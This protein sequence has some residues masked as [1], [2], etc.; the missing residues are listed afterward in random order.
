MSFLIVNT[1]RAASR[2]FYL[3]LRAQPGLLT[4]S[5][6]QF[7]NM[8]TRYICLNFKGN[9][10][11]LA[12][13]VQ[14]ARRITESPLPH[15]IVFHGAR[16]RLAYPFNSRRNKALLTAVRNE[17]GIDSVF[18]VIRDSEKCFL[19]ELNRRLAKPLGDWKFPE[20]QLG[21]KKT[22][23]VEDLAD[24]KSRRIPHRDPCLKDQLKPN[25]DI[26][27]LARKSSVRT[28]KLFAMY[29]LFHS[30]FPEVY[31][32]R[33]ERFL[34][35]PR[36]IFDQIAS[37]IGF[38]FSDYSLAEI[39][40]NS[41]SNRLLIYNP[42]TLSL[43]GTDTRWGGNWHTSFSRFALRQGRQV[44]LR[45]EIQ[46][47]IQLCDDWGVYQPLGPDCSKA[48][49]HVANDLGGRIGIGVHVDDLFSLSSSDRALIQNRNFL[50]ELIE[51]LA[52]VFEKNYDHSKTLYKSTYFTELPTEAKRIF[53][54]ING[55]EN[56]KMKSIIEKNPDILL[57]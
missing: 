8:V 45:F 27:A 14:T 18:L 28:G 30:V 29:Q 37:K 9:I 43:A 56:K 33:Y 40:L 39:K 17:L 6:T 52:P 23:S 16:P 26:S 1:G 5:R 47:V 15:G 2:A 48:L 50:E 51:A 21:W 10:H 38:R 4:C 22:F 42:V 44:R 36:S 53:W 32:I 55:E 13:T 49:P 34:E 20:N 57:Q 19:S 3:N 54:E 12:R 35:N 31:L 25:M 24:I 11:S 46:N 41:L 7:D